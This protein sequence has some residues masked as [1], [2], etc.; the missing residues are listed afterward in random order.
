MEE[1]GRTQLQQDVAHELPLAHFGHDAKPLGD[2]AEPALFLEKSLGKGVV[3]EDESLAGGKVVL[4]LDPVQHL[5]RRLLREGQEK[6]L[7]GRYAVLSQP[8]VTLD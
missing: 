7:L 3:G 1:V 2:A 6:D 5:A 4:L 8:A